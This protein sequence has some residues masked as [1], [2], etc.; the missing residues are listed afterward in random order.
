MLWSPHTNNVDSLRWY[1]SEAIQSIY[2]YFGSGKTGNPV[3]AM[4]TGSGKTHVISGFMKR[5][6]MQYPSQRFLVSTHVKELVAQNSDKLAKSWH[7]APFGVHSAGL[8]QRE[9]QQPII[10][11]GIQSMYKNAAAFG[12]RDLL[13]IDEA[14]LVSPDDDTMYQS[15]VD[16]LR[17]INPN[18]KVIGLSATIWRQKQ[19]LITN[20]VEGGIFTDIAYNL[21][22]MEGFARLIAEGHLVPIYPKRTSFEIDVSNVGVSSFD[23]N[24][25]QLAENMTD[26]IMWAALQEAARFG[27]NRRSWLVFAAGIERTEKCVEMLNY[28]GIPAVAV[29]S[30]L[31][32]PK[33]RDRR[34]EAHK[35][36]EVR[37]MVGNNIFT[38]GYDHPPLDFCIDLQPTM[39]VAK[40]VQKCGRLM[41]PS[42]ETGK[43]NGLYLDFAGNTRRCGPINDPYVPQ[44]KRKGPPGDAPVKICDFCGTYNHASV[45][46]CDACGEEFEFETKIVHEASEAEILKS[47]LPD[48]QPF[49]VDAVWY[50]KH[51]AKRTGI[52]CLKVIY[53]SGLQM[54]TEWVHLENPGFPG[55][56]ARD[57]WRQR[58]AIEPPTTVDDAL[59]YHTELR[60]PRVIHVWLNREPQEITKVDW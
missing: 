35:K 38:T 26:Q 40:H 30:K 2:D 23:F 12:W 18:L 43:E 17:K 57:W 60:V 5:A 9:T 4:P 55:K 31:K 42:V 21:C 10:I 1:Q 48:V 51:I 50:Y 3:I 58:H 45:R 46:F 6:L 56:R 11:G 49:N 8:K 25:K 16:E 19:G 32:D 29:H 7:H 27:Q 59:R 36:G 52:P 20:S 24:Q 34:I 13:I 14:H 39:S 53:R 15:F 41:R 33:E 28:M 44:M 37:V 47:D 54:F 22:T